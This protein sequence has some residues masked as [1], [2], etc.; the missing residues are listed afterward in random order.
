[1]EPT[2]QSMP[3]RIV[4]G[5]GAKF[6]SVL[7]PDANNFQVIPRLWHEFLPRMDEI[8]HR[9][10]Q[11]AL[12]CVYC[13]ASN[14]GHGPHELY[15]LAALEVTTA[16]DVPAG[17]EVREIPAGKHAVF[18]HKGRLDSLGQTMNFI[19]GTWFPASEYQK[20]NAPELEIYGPRFDSNSDE[21]EL[22]ICIPIQ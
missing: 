2:I 18:I 17:L 5:L 6:T 12:G 1:M 19:H 22:E 21:S 8:P 20:R 7:S 16:S 14:E 11:T 13:P 10:S 9:K 3:A 4:V 15:Y